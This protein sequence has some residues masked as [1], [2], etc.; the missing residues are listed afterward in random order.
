ML[1]HGLHHTQSSVASF[2]LTGFD[3]SLKLKQALFSP[4]QVFSRDMKA[5]TLHPFTPQALSWHE[6]REFATSWQ[7]Q[8]F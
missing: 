8:A 5:T 6:D 1:F 3:L 4:Y 2:P 7:Q